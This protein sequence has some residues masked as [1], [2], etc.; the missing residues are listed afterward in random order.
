M[1][2]IGQQRFELSLDEAGSLAAL[3]GKKPVHTAL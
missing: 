1:L 3:W 2:G